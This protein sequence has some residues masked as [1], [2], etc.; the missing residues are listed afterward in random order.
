MVLDRKRKIP[1]IPKS[2]DKKTHIFLD[3]KTGF[4]LDIKTN[5]PLNPKILRIKNQSKDTKTKSPKSLE[6]PINPQM[7]TK[8]PSP[9]RG[10]G[11]RLNPNLYR[12]VT[13]LYN[14][15]VISMLT[16]A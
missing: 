9:R 15:Y 6:K 13:N 14:H 10:V 16:N 8:S 4:F 11:V 7:T 1:K 12:F 3:R 5:N 2:Q